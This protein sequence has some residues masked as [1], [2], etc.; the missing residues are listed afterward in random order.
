M[1]LKNK[2]TS[3]FSGEGVVL[4]IIINQSQSSLFLGRSNIFRFLQ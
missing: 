2:T 4:V 1:D 3:S